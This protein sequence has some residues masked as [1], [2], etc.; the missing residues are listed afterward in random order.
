MQTRAKT[1]SKLSNHMSSGLFDNVSPNYGKRK[2]IVEGVASGAPQSL[3]GD[4][5]RERGLGAAVQEA[6]EH[7][8]DRQ[9]FQKAL[10]ADELRRKN[11]QQE[12]R[13]KHGDYTPVYLSLRI[14][15]PFNPPRITR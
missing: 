10:K 12:I 6:N 4:G 9:Q 8:T 7:L 1:R 15:S 5:P 14:R 11:V 3:C 13:L 2:F